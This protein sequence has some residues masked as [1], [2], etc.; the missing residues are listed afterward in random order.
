[1]M[2]PP[3]IS[4]AQKVAERIDADAVV[5]LAFNGDGAVAGAS[6]G[7]TKAICRVTGK[8]MDGLIDKMAAGEL[9]SPL[10]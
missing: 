8:W 1:M 4:W 2:H 6:Y 10:T 3:K 5:I 7:E 9:P